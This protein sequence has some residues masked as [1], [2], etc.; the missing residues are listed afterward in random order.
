MER[1]ANL[2]PR[3]NFVRERMAQAWRTVLAMSVGIAFCFLLDPARANEIFNMRGVAVDATAASSAEARDLAF[4][5]GQS[6]AF[7]KLLRRLTLENDETLRAVRD[8]ISLADLIAGFEVDEEKVSPTRYRALLT[9]NF[10]PDAVRQTLRNRAI[11]FAETV[12][13]PVL[14]VPVLREGATAALWK[15]SNTWRNAW[16]RRETEPGDLVPLVLP[17]GDIIDISALTVEQVLLPD[18]D[19]LMRLA[20]RYGTNEIAAAIAVITRPAPPVTSGGAQP[21]PAS[22]DD[23]N[24][25]PQGVPDLA[26]E[27]DLQVVEPD[28][29]GWRLDLSVRRLGLAGSQSADA[30]LQGQTG[31]TVDDLMTR[32][33]QRIVELLSNNWKMANLLQFD[34]SNALLVR[35]PLTSLADWV[36]ARRRLS[37]MAVVADVQ[38]VEL[39]LDHAVIFLHHLGDPEQLTLA[40]EQVDLA[41]SFE[42]EGWTLQS[43]S[44]QQREP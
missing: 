4:R 43:A 40:L 26:T 1:V 17:L 20:G 16:M 34:R 3:A 13:K 15:D 25:V 27:P 21:E 22:P 32:G 41:L 10:K 9:I 14:V 28:V 42:A 6:E 29:E 38:L 24:A 31:E 30:V 11:S 12:S 5:A 44:T 23:A 18:N 37:G 7:L 2:P 19:A 39:M 33:A 35:V 8:S 36:E